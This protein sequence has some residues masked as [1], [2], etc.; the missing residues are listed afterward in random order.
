MRGPELGE[1]P[2]EWKRMAPALE[3][4]IHGHVGASHLAQATVV[5]C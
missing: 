5:R 2:S 1:S 4:E 3:R